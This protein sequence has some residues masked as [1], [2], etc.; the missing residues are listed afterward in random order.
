M[1]EA[2]HIWHLFYAF[3]PIFYQSDRKYRHHVIDPD[4]ESVVNDLYTPTD[5]F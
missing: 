5:H 3:K 1:G 2:L 4:A